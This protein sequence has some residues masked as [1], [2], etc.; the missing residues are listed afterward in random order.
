MGGGGT[1][2]FVQGSISGAAKDFNFT[3]GSI[4]DVTLATTATTKS[5][6][7]GTISAPPSIPSETV[8]LNGAKLKRPPRLQKPA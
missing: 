2:G 3:G 1:L 4:T 5:R 8:W 7:S 6:I